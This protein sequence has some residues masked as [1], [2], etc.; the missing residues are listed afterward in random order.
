MD[1]V[2]LFYKEVPEGVDA[3]AMVPALTGYEE[4]P[5]ILVGGNCSLQVA[6]KHEP[7][8]HLSGILPE[9]RR[10]LLDGGQ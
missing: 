8:A 5:L 6:D 2:E 3:L 4:T 7:I 9:R 1:N 10:Y